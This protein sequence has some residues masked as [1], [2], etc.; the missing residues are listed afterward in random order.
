MHGGDVEGDYTSGGGVRLHQMVDALLRFLRSS[1][2]V[3][4]VNEC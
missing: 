4:V 3:T 2:D 1:I